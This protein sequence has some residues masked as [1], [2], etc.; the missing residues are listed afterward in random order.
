M[1]FC[2]PCTDIGEEGTVCPGT[3][4][5]APRTCHNN[6]TVK[7]EPVPRQIHGNTRCQC[8]KRW[9]GYSGVAG[10]QKVAELSD[11]ETLEGL[12]CSKCPRGV[13]CSEAGNE[14]YKLQFAPNVWQVG[15]ARR[16]GRARCWVGERC[17][18][19]LAGDHGGVVV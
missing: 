5:S 3:G 2:T 6:G 1:Q 15:C 10:V 14:F 11:E 4:L 19:G 18:R 16:L 12:M 17:S 13:L 7:A 9:F 8:Q